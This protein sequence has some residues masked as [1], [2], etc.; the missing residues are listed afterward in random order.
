MSTIRGAGWLMMGAGM[1]LTLPL[2]KY[3]D[4]FLFAIKR[5]HFNDSIF[6]WLASSDGLVFDM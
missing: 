4:W 2:R 1:N 6:Y 5:V 3:L